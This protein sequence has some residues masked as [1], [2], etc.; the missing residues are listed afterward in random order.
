LTGA[1]EA[2]LYHVLRVVGTECGRRR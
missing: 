2:R 1:V